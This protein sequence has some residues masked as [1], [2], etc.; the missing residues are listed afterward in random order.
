MASVLVS[1]PAQA[2]VLGPGSIG[3]FPAPADSAGLVMAMSR[4]GMPAMPK[5]LSVTCLVSHDNGKTFNPLV[6]VEIPGGDILQ[7]GGKGILAET[8]VTVYWHRVPTHVRLD[9]TSYAAF[10]AAFRVESL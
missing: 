2:I 5:V 6:G 7:K 1:V 4:A 9:L 3:P 10:T 8:D